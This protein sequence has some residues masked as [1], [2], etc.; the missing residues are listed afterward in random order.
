MEEKDMKKHIGQRILI[1]RNETFTEQ[2]P[3]NLRYGALD[4]FSQTK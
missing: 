3:L 2:I 4:V 1:L